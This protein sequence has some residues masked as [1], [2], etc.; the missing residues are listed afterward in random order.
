MFHDHFAFID[1]GFRDH[2]EGLIP[3]EE[4]L[5]AAVVV[6][7]G[8]HIDEGLELDALVILGIAEPVGDEAA[9][10][11]EGISDLGSGG[12]VGVEVVLVIGIGFIAEVGAG[13]LGELLEDSAG[14]E[15][16]FEAFA[17]QAFLGGE[18]HGLGGEDGAGI[19]AFDFGGDLFGEVGHGVLGLGFHG[20]ECVEGAG[21]DEAAE[22]DERGGEDEEDEASAQAA[23]EGDFGG[24]VHAGVGLRL[25]GAQGRGLVGFRL[26]WGGGDV[27]GAGWALGWWVVFWTRVVLSLVELG[28]GCLCWRACARF[29]SRSVS[30]V[31]TFWWGRGY[32]RGWGL[33]AA[34]WVYGGGAWW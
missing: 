15:A 2:G 13:E 27:V 25:V 30:A 12:G 6:E 18:G 21:D 9:L 26:V 33:L 20:F 17:E 32:W 22:D 28:G 14:V 8:F 29:E 34:R 10:R 31:M 7:A 19:T 1:V 4:E 5:A 3:G 16:G 23:V 24:G 11:G